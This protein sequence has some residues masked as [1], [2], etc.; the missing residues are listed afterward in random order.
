MDIQFV[1]L[2][3]QY[4][5]YKRDIDAQMQDVITHSS[6]IMGQQV[7]EL[8]N[9]LAKF[10]GSQ[11]A[12]GCSSGTDALLLALMAYE[13][14]PGDE[15]ITTPFT[16]IATAE[17]IAHLKATPVFADIQPETFNIDPRKIEAAVTKKT[18]GIIA[19]DL[20]GQCADYDEI[21]T[22]AKKYNFFVI[23]D[24]AQ[25][26]GAEYKGKKACSLTEISCT[27]FF[28]AKPLGCFGDG[29]M[30]FTDDDEKAEIIRSLRL[31]GKGSHKYDIHRIG[32]NARLDTLQAAI[33]LA[34][35]KY[36][37]QEIELRNHAA[38][39]YT[40]QLGDIVVTPKILKHNKSTF[41][42]YSILTERRDE[43]Q[44][45]LKKQGIPTAIHY[46]KALHLQKALAYLGKRQGDFPITEKMCQNILS[47]PMHPYIT[48]EEINFIVKSIQK[49]FEK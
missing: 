3:R 38:S 21:H 14:G 37:P 47:L 44:D 12:I 20:F 49:F 9:Q 4:Q 8:E 23:E 42:Q 27:S 15:V 36:F 33:V 46:P 35:F 22:I 5:K 24:A 48:D 6:F 17:V 41:A 43:L 39:V 1:D 30:I 26:F 45:Y 18:R 11:Y 25:S 31:H 2:Q 40:Q 13:I 7:E 29:G 19:V 32:I 28:P 10:V 16:F 34:K